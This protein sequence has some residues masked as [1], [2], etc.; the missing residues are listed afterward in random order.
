MSIIIIGYFLKLGFCIEKGFFVRTIKSFTLVL[1][2]GT[3]FLPILW[4]SNSI[5]Q[6]QTEV[7]FSIPSHLGEIQETYQASQNSPMVVHIQDAHC[8]YDAQKSTAQIIE[9]LV[10]QENFKLI[11]ME[12]A[13]GVIDTSILKAL[14]ETYRQQGIERLLKRARIN[15]VDY[16]S[17]T[18]KNASD[19]FISGIEE[20]ESY[21]ANYQ[22]FLDLV[23]TKGKFKEEL[24]WIKTK[25]NN[26]KHKIYSKPL[27]EFEK[28]SQRFK[29]DSIELLDYLERL[30]QLS[31]GQLDLSQ[32]GQIRRILS[33]QQGEDLTDKQIAKRIQ[34][35][36]GNQLFV[37]LNQLEADIKNIY[38]TN[39][40]QRLVDSYANYIRLFEKG[41]H[42]SLIPAEVQAFREGAKQISIEDIRTIIVEYFGIKSWPSEGEWNS[43]I[44]K[45]E[46]FYREVENRDEMMFNNLSD[47][48]NQH[49]SEKTIVITGGYHSRGMKEHYRKHNI[50][51][52]TVS[53]K[54]AELDTKLTDQLY[55]NNLISQATWKYT[56]ALLDHYD[57]ALAE[58]TK[59]SEVR[60]DLRTVFEG[61][62]IGP[63]MWA[64][65]TE[66]FR[67]SLSR[68]VGSTEA[69]SY[70]D[71]IAYWS[72]V[73][74][75]VGASSLGE[76]KVLFRDTAVKEN[77]LFA[78]EKQKSLVSAAEA[79]LKTIKRYIDFEVGVVGVQNGKRS[80]VLAEMGYPD[81]A[82]AMFFRYVEGDTRKLHLRHG[83]AIFD[84][85][86]TGSLEDESREL[87]DR[88]EIEQ[89]FSIPFP[90]DDTRNGLMQ[91][92]FKK[93]SEVPEEY[94]KVLSDIKYI[95]SLGFKK[96]S[97][98]VKDVEREKELDETRQ[99]LQALE[100]R[101][102]RLEQLR[103]VGEMSA[104]V[105]HEVNNALTIIR[106]NAE[107]ALDDLVADKRIKAM[108]Q[109]DNI[110]R[111]SERATMLAKAMLTLSKPV[112][113]KDSNVSLQSII[114]ETVGIV[115]HQLMKKNIR[116]KIDFAPGV[117]VVE[118]NSS[119]MIQVF[120]NLFI[121]ASHAMSSG[122]VLEVKAYPLG[123]EYIQIVVSDN[124]K[125]MSRETVKHIFDPFYTTKKTGTGL[126]L[127]VTKSIL[128]A[129][130]A[131]VQV[132]S[133]QG[134]GTQFT[135]TFP[136][137]RSANDDNLT[138]G[139]RIEKIV[140]KRPLIVEDSP[141]IQI[142]LTKKAAEQMDIEQTAVTVV[143][144]GDEALR[145]IQARPNAFDIILMDLRMPGLS[146]VQTAEKLR[147]LYFNIPIVII[148][149]EGENFE[150]SRE[151]LKKGVINAA[152]P[153]PIQP[154]VF[155]KVLRDLS[156]DVT[157]GMSLGSEAA[158]EELVSD[159]DEATRNLFGV[160]IIEEQH[161]TQ[162]AV[163]I[164]IADYLR[165]HP[166]AIIWV[167]WRNTYLS[168]AQRDEVR[169]LVQSIVGQ[170]NNPERFQWID[171]TKT[172]N[173]QE[174]IEKMLTGS[175][176]SR[177]WNLARQ[178]NP[179]L[180]KVSD[181][182]PHLS[183]LSSQETQ[184]W[185]K[186]HQH[187]KVISYP[188]A[189]LPEVG[190]A[191]REVAELKMGVMA[192]RLAA[193]KGDWQLLNQRYSQ[194]FKKESGVFSYHSAFLEG[195]K[196]LVNSFLAR[197]S[198]LS[199]A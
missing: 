189:D 73:R 61:V 107:L 135:L 133:T 159:S 17:A 117:G 3:V 155:K 32:Y 102:P 67:V 153:K 143:A 5:G 149:G 145:V 90:L 169:G 68:V 186:A 56:L 96:V 136:V 127:A 38:F 51:Y 7:Q 98:E 25:I 28:I 196:A 126:G 110:L 192:A 21:F 9:H 193:F 144:S 45:I 88:M 157:Q 151:L 63:E 166:N 65:M 94:R 37:E 148:T 74:D 173:Q 140:F 138:I 177:L 33:L 36:D 115:E 91:I 194:V 176:M 85:P 152:M 142:M 179:E 76:G 158:Y 29:N 118:A 80:Y 130:N 93:G 57:A 134:V 97:R 160:T 128:D 44:D 119:Q 39:E 195:L 59:A 72:G 156:F 124:G 168:E 12:G 50:S 26:I 111:G 167:P 190:T 181:L 120:L 70:Q 146:G 22:A 35:L 31:K 188:A 18:S 54:I 129:H 2:L 141:L 185:F 27:R 1:L 75:N 191:E 81:T 24:K 8:V 64:Q 161:F 6:E 109:L 150:G 84:A 66:E 122:G 49:K 123:E 14:P 106:G 52:S 69:G 125:G 89:L 162:P 116:I 4:A 131:E 41:V 43:V 121:N 99:R 86:V 178:L 147:E 11:L 82:K 171:L 103:M 199:S 154:G 42:L 108:T 175:T 105:A 92:A 114:N 48:I 13:F 101:L 60:A 197:K 71:A 83:R 95:L 40:K 172:N 20:K 165:G 139:F 78:F 198:S 46:Q 77:L 62:S 15:G 16:F 163:A 100:E 137:Q 187:I 182:L 10:G 112:H 184:Q 164:G 30:I 87:V 180:K 79:V 47:M 19:V 132:S 55:L 113:I 174:A 183:V 34:Q 23:E 58:S 104:G 170:D 53:P